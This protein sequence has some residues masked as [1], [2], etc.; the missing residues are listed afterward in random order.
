MCRALDIL[1]PT[2]RESF[3][4]RGI[5]ACAY[6]KDMVHHNVNRI[7]AIG[8]PVAPISAVST[9][10]QACGELGDKDSGLPSKLILC[11]QAKFRLTANLWTDAGLTNGSTGIV[12]SIIYSPDSKPPG[13]VFIVKATRKVSDFLLELNF[14]NTT[15]IHIF[16]ITLGKYLH[17]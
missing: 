6:K 15:S 14:L 7:K 5:L 1:P 4:D 16:I 8:Q 9:P 17:T 10:R 13:P 12:H 11:R 3:L 2:E